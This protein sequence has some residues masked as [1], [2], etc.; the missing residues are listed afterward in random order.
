MKNTYETRKVN[1]R[2]SI[3]APSWVKDSEDDFDLN[4]S[5]PVEGKEADESEQEQQ[6]LLTQS[7]TPWV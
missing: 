6:E 5:A 2:D 7:D 1:L 3:D 4:E